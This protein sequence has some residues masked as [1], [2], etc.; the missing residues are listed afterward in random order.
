[1]REPSD[2]TDR[3]ITK[4]VTKGAKINAESCLN[5]S[6]ANNTNARKS[7]KIP[8]FMNLFLKYRKK[9]GELTYFGKSTV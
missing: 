4:M 1:M 7:T 9:Y 8:K 3:I 5:A 2:M 6:K